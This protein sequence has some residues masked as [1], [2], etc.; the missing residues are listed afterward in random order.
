MPAAQWVISK[1]CHKNNPSRLSAQNG[2]SFNII[3]FLYKLL[4]EL[5]IR[6]G[7]SPEESLAEIRLEVP[8]LRPL[9]FILHTLN[10]EFQVQIV[11]HAAKLI[12]KIIFSLI[13][14]CTGCKGTVNFDDCR[15]QLTKVMEVGLSGSKIIQCQLDLHSLQLCKEMSLIYILLQK[16]TFCQLNN[17]RIRRK[18]GFLHSCDHIQN[19]I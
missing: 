18:L 10:A 19:Y 14:H 15:T 9:F 1:S 13:C 16:I 5:L 6:A 12:Q 17:K 11:D 2:L 4:H 8:N 3:L 7:S